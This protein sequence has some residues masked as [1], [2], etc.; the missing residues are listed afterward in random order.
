VAASPSVGSRATALLVARNTAAHPPAV[1]S[2]TTAGRYSRPNGLPPCGRHAA[3]PAVPVA[4][5]VDRRVL[6]PVSYRGA[7]MPTPSRWLDRRPPR[8]QPVALTAAVPHAANV[9]GPTGWSTDPPR[10]MRSSVPEPF[11][12]AR[13]R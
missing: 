12:E 9:C 13:R 8:A 7:G 5:T 1:T 2:F 6:A 3:F 10:T 4:A 11:R